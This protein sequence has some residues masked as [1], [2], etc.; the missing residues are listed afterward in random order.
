MDID[1]TK[2]RR[3]NTFKSTDYYIDFG[4][5]ISPSHNNQKSFLLLAK[6]AKRFVEN[7]LK[8][9]IESTPS[10]EDDSSENVTPPEDVANVHQGEIALD[11]EDQNH[12]DMISSYA[13]NDSDEE[14]VSSY[15]SDPEGEPVRF[16]C[17]EISIYNY[18]SQ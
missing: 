13:G 4:F 1:A 6:K 14:E 17:R 18:I 16:L 9:E 10:S 7:C 12:V 3:G 5:E 15:T 2:L 11:P 8:L